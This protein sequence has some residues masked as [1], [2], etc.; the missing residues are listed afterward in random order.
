[1]TLNQVAALAL[2]FL[3]A[4]PSGHTLFQL[5]N[6]LGIY[7][8]F[9]NNGNPFQA[10]ICVLVH[11]YLVL[12]NL[13]HLSQAHLKSVL[14]DL[15]FA[16]ARQLFRLQRLRELTLDDLWPVPERYQFRNSYNELKFNVDEP[17]FVIRAIVRMVWKPMIPLHIAGMLLQT[18]PIMKTML[19]GYIYQC[20]DSPE[21][22][23]YYRA[24]VAAVG[25]IVL[26]VLSAQSIHLKAYLEK[27]KNIIAGTLNLEIKRMPM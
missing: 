2:P 11:T 10:A 7:R 12:S 4:H 27:E 14:R 20:L 21:S 24:Y 15:S 22:N 9:N 6:A 13:D 17:L 16:Q 19:N 3:A 23:T 5:A 1:M 25:L 26:E 8:V 18:I